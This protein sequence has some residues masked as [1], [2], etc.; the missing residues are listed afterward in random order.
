MSGRAKLEIFGGSLVFGL[1]AGAFAGALAIAMGGGAPAF[2][3]AL[4]VG[5]ALSV[6]VGR[7]RRWSWLP[8]L[9]RTEMEKLLDP[10]FAPPSAARAIDLDLADRWAQA[11][12]TRDWATA[13]VLLH[14]D[15]AGI[16]P[17]GRTQR[18]WLYMLSAR[19][20]SDCYVD[21]A[22]KVEHVLAED[23]EPSVAWVCF[24]EVARPMRGEPLSVT[25][26]ER[27][28]LDAERASI[29]EIRVGAVTAIA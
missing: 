28:T 18:R 12:M 7:V 27:W 21:F 17:K 5:F 14:P 6:A 19:M 4:L 23:D 26:W 11:L 20:L 1:L 16:P 13:K 8:K 10:G 25:W 3:I 15:F 24:S 29:R 9:Y 22:M 2:V